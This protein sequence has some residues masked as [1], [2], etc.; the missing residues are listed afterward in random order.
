MNVF[1]FYY[2][3][4]EIIIIIIIIIIIFPMNQNYC[5]ISYEPTLDACLILA[6]TKPAFPPVKSKL[7]NLRI[8]VWRMIWMT[9]DFQQ[10][11]CQIA[12]T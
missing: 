1:H 6:H 4:I 7:F 2:Y 9:T 8:C 3:M 11:A 12:E 10:Y 5:N